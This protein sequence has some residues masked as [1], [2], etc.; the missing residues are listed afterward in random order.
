MLFISR[1]LFGH[2]SLDSSR[3]KCGTV[4]TEIEKH[5]SD[6]DAREI[7]RIRRGQSVSSWLAARLNCS[8]ILELF[9]VFLDLFIC[10]QS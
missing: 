6:K 4:I 7:R 10:K 2:Q 1:S 9:S 3:I 8:V 5:V